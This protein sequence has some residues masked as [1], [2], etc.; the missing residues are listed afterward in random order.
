MP[1]IVVVAFFFLSSFSLAKKRP[2]RM[3]TCLSVHRSSKYEV[4]I[5]NTLYKRYLP[6]VSLPLSSFPFSFDSFLEKRG[7]RNY[8]IHEDGRRGWREFAVFYKSKGGEREEKRFFFDT[9]VEIL[10]LC[11]ATYRN[12]TQKYLIYLINCELNCCIYCSSKSLFIENIY[13]KW[14][15]KF[16]TKK[17][18]RT[19]I[20]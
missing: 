14:Q 16:R 5:F 3:Y 2:I 20:T 11:Y 1:T 12:N 13:N 15:E 7:K 4:R 6:F 17:I 19:E 18:E 9:N 8:V 10:F